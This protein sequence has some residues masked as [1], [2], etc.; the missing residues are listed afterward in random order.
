MTYL[1][2]CRDKPDHLA[3]R[4]A[5][6]EAHLG[7]LKDS[8][9]VTLAGP[10]LAE[11]GAMV[12]SLLALDVPDRAAAEAFAAGDPYAKAGLFASVEIVGWRRVIG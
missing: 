9:V 4:A 10:L 5:N 12:G 3:V 11:D 7:Y 6:R 8:G 2:I 1:L